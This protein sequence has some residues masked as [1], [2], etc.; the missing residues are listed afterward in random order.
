MM[1]S[2]LYRS[3]IT[4]NFNYHH[5]NFKHFVPFP[6]KIVKK[7][8]L[9]VPKRNYLLSL[10]KEPDNSLAKG[11]EVTMYIKGFLSPGESVHR[12]GTWMERHE[13]LQ[14][15]HKIGFQTYSSTHKWHPKAVGYYWDS[16][17]ISPLP[18]ATAASI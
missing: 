5:A 4:F 7:F 1:L 6:C 12:F 17:T 3:R 15:Y 10:S 16:K 11:N 13:K 14:R 18:I 8:N 9:S 2:N